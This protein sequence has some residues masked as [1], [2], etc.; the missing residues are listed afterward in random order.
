MRNKKGDDWF[1]F[2][3]DK[4]FFGSTKYE[5]TPAERSV[6]VDLM[7]L[8]KKDGGYIRANVGCPYSSKQLA[9]LFIVPVKLLNKTI[10]KALEV[11]KLRKLEDGTYYVA[12]TK[13]YTI[14]ERHKR[15]LKNQMMAAETDIESEPADSL[16]KEGEKD[17]DIEKDKEGE[18][19]EE[20]KPPISASPK[21]TIK[22]MSEQIKKDR[23]FGKCCY[24]CGQSKNTSDRGRFRWVEHL[25]FCWSRQCYEKWVENGRPAPASQSP[26]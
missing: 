25:P 2:Y 9:G 26:T 17:V 19:K 24:Y 10:A 1:P 15:R 12:S 20:N 8:S 22:E 11:G 18:K 23:S 14:S 13:K 5:F 4:W 3:I 16:F 21:P 6:W 7:A